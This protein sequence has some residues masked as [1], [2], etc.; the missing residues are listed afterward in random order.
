MKKVVSMNELIWGTLFSTV[1]VMEIIV[2]FIETTLNTFYLFLI[3]ASIIL[4]EWLIIFLILKYVLGKGLPLDSILS[5]FG[6][7]EP[8]VGRKCRKNIFYFEKVCLEITIIAIQKKKDILI[9]SWLIS[10]RN[11]EKYFGKSVEYFGPTCIQKF[12]N[13]INRVTFQ[14][15]N[16][17]KCIR[18]V[19]HTNALTSEQIGVID[20]K[21]KELEER[22]N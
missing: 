7:I 22:N 21:L 5:P 20:A 16:R 13:W 12:V 1:I 3:M 4:L 11:L 14:R 17:K 2:L 6:F 18:C 19:I 10:K 15:K 8:H 9:D